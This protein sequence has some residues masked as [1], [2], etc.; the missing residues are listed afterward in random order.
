MLGR[1]VTTNFGWRRYLD[2]EAGD[3]GSVP[4]RP[5]RAVASME[6]C[7]SGE[8]A[9]GREGEKARGREGDCACTQLLGLCLRFLASV[10]VN[11]NV[12]VV[13]L[14]KS[15]KEPTTKP[16]TNRSSGQNE[17]FISAPN[18]IFHY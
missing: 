9:R 12:N 1:G 13:Q 8:T 7:R 10:N 5:D 17:L 18:W 16:H 4:R 6:T 3:T 11:V 14:P 15:M 2:S